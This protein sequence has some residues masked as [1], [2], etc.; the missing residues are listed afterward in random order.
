M[1]RPESDADPAKLRVYGRRKGKPLKAARQA[2]L[3]NVL[4]RCRIDLPAAGEIINP[5]TLFAKPVRAVWFEVGFGAGEHLAAHAARNPDI[6]IIGSEVFLN[7]V[8]G[9]A[10]RVGEEN[11]S[12]VR[13]FDDDARK[14]LSVLPDAAISRLFVMFPDPWPK[15]RH[16]K[17]RFISP[18]N[19]DLIS[20]VLAD[21]AELRVASDDAG[22]VRWSLM[23]LTRH[24][25]F[26]WRVE[27][28][29]DWRKP[30]ADSVTT[31][32]QQ[33]AVNQGRKPVFLVFERR[34]RVTRQGP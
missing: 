29:D 10:R 6:G 13:I 11:L 3:T 17:R 19:L 4:P 16:A 20:R 5:K 27:G 7:G 8:A 1:T 2:A 9:L 24:P 22:Y 30:P 21:G 31:R 14:I 12:N 18:D 26:R 32:Y 28:P 34:A 23:Q 33:K 25:A 15:V